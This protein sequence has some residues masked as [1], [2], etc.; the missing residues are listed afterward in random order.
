MKKKK[1]LFIT[2]Q[3]SL[4]GAP[5]VLMDMIRVV[6]EAG[7]QIEVISMVQGPLSE[8]L[9]QFHIPWRIEKDFLGNWKS[10]YREV[11][12]FDAVV[13]NTLVAYK[14]ILILNR[15]NI[16]TLWW[17]HESKG[18]FD[19]YEKMKEIVP[20]ISTLNSNVRVYPVSPRVQQELLDRFG[21]QSDI[22][23]FALP[24]FEV[25]KENKSKNSV[26]F[27][28][29]GEYSHRK[30]L[31]VLCQ[32]IG[33]LDEKVRKQ[34]RFFV[35]GAETQLE[36]GFRTELQKM[37]HA[38]PN[39]FLEEVVSHEEA[40]K[41]LSEADYCL[42][43]SR[44]DPMPT[45][46]AEA[47]VLGKPCV[48][49]DA[50]GITAYLGEDNAFVC[51]AADAESLCRRITDAVHLYTRDPEEYRR[52][53]NAARRV[54]DDIFSMEAFRPRILRLMKNLTERRR[55]IFV[56]G[57]ID[58]LD[59]FSLEMI[60]EFHRLG[61][62]TLEF[63][64][65]DGETDLK[66]FID[67]VKGGKV[68]AAILYNHYGLD[69]SIIPGKN[70]WESLGIPVVDILMDHPYCHRDGLL[71]APASTIVLCVDRNHMNYL[72]R[73]HKKLQTVGF[74]PHGGLYDG[75]P[76][77]TIKEREITILYAGTLSR[78]FVDQIMPD[79]ASFS[80]D[81][82]SVVRQTVERNIANPG[83]TMESV[84]EEVLLE[85]G[86][87]L[88]D[89]EL[90][91]VIA[92]LHYAD[93]LIVS[94]YREKVVKTLALSG[95]PIRLYGLG[96]GELP[97]VKECKNVDYRGRV[98][99]WEIVREMGNTKIVLS[100]HTWFKDGT[101]DRIFNGMLSRAVVVTDSSRYMKEN[102][103]DREL[104][105]FELSEIELLPDR[106]QKLLEDP[107]R[108]QEIADRGYKKA[109]KTESHQARAKEMDRDLL[110]YL[111]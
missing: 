52:M 77:K 100:T 17:L 15:T 83:R 102:F 67:F 2:H 27:I 78:G 29:L 109:M 103:S 43:P 71:Y 89:E 63:K 16:P 57:Q 37:V 5:I 73:F 3:L 74:L 9:D 22:L 66:A 105:Q 12:E 46:A 86:V 6:K 60:P 4:S 55:L 98:D 51:G 50:C 108:M 10:I 44:D 104:I 101:H 94:H 79:F 56:T 33:M 107:D 95:L 80:F 41:L 1:I 28:T 26:D 68:C 97:W 18:Y 59:I 25:G 23:P 84:M 47:M 90:C 7:Y 62:E 70:T 76:K 106:L 19:D 75:L 69:L 96:W 21:L 31:D 48:I 58:I 20:D 38:Y 82:K 24:D 110:Q 65:K 99:A 88:S 92:D 39:V 13:V 32:A 40:M 111:G 87:R 61:Y 81:A 49:S 85:M 91:R 45:I 53:G 54:Y 8:T 36:K 72:S 30:G 14:A 93:L 11:L 35:Y 34:C 42:V 64:L